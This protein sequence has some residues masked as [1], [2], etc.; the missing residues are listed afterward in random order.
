MFIVNNTLF[1]TGASRCAIIIWCF[2]LPGLSLANAAQPWQTT[3]FII[4]SFYETVLG[5]E[6]GRGVLKV[7]KW[8][9]AVSIYVAHQV[10]DTKLHNDLLNAQIADLR[11]ITGLKITR[12]NNKSAADIQ[13]YFTSQKQ[14]S[15]LVSATSGKESLQYIRGAVCLATMK[16]KKSGEIQSAMIYIPVDQA[17]MHAK[18]LSCVVEE[19]TQTM[20]IPRDSDA[21]Y[22]SIFND[23]T[24]ND[25]LTGLDVVLLKLLYSSEVKQG[26]G[27]AQLKPVLTNLIAKMRRQGVIT[28]ANSY[29]RSLKVCRL[30]GC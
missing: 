17:R 23:K 14:L 2:L 9:K 26:M 4:N 29:A 25:Y 18:L 22:P 27:K 6:Y 12:V 15:G 8:S 30:A 21:V 16:A 1:W 3:P 5:N 24:P 10:P 11:A 20:G 28:S 7:R 19:L 13:Y